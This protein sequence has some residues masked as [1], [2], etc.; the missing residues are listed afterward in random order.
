MVLCPKGCLLWNL[1]NGE[2]EIELAE[3]EL[4]G[5]S[6]F[7]FMKFL[8]LSLDTIDSIP[9]SELKLKTDIIN[10]YYKTNMN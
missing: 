3:V 4:F 6:E 5:N 10:L 8:R 1:I 9:N 7:K 2:L